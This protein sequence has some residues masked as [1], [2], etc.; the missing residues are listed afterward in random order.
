MSQYTQYQHPYATTYPAYTY[1]QQYVQQTQLQP[2]QQYQQQPTYY[3]QQPQAQQ[4][5]FPAFAGSTPGPAASAQLQPPTRMAST[6]PHTPQPHRRNTSAGHHHRDS[7]TSHRPSTASHQYSASLQ[8][9]NSVSHQQQQQ[10]Q[11]QQPVRSSL[12]R[13][14]AVSGI[15]N[16][17]A[18]PPVQPVPS[19]QRARTY[20]GGTAD[21]PRLSSVRSRTNSFATRELLTISHIFLTIKAPDLLEV[22]NIVQP[23]L[24]TRIQDVCKEWHRPVHFE[25]KDFDILAKFTGRP[26]SIT[27]PDSIMV[28]RM[29]VHLFILLSH[30]GY[31]VLT[32][33]NNGSGFAAPRL[34]FVRHTPDFTC[35]FFCMQQHE[36][37]ISFVDASRDLVENLTLTLNGIFRK[38]FSDEELH[39]GVMAIRRRPGN[40]VDNDRFYGVV[41]KYLNEACLKLDASISL[42]RTGFLG[43]GPRQELWIFK[44]SDLW[45]RGEKR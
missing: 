9:S 15:T 35:T 19:I 22:N 29:L 27:G 42:G 23:D 31:A 10:Q 16:A 20:S 13:R 28:R 36:W 6:R 17:A 2:Q 43:F 30:E 32:S 41:L 12:R 18:P 44:G 37:G 3:L 45:Q 25:R 5:T 38:A 39:P 33:V 34:V 26:F 1:P 24:L 40:H 14:P 7:R 4:F 21:R 11:Y 8:H